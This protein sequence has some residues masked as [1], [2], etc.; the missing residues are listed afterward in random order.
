VRGFTGGPRAHHSRMK[1]FSSIA[2]FRQ[3]F[4]NVLFSRERAAR[5]I[6]KFCFPAVLP[7]LPYGEM[8]IFAPAILF[9]PPI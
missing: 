3:K 6:A 2:L 8:A 5:L 9:P 1:L 7:S 4:L